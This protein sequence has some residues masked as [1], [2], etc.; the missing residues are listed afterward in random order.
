MVEQYLAPR[1]SINE[2]SPTSRA[3]LRS[4]NYFCIK[5]SSNWPYYGMRENRVVFRYHLLKSPQTKT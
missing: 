2:I 4:Y 3:S 1:C 5:L